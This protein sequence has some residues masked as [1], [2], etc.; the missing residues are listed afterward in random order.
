MCRV[1]IIL[2][3]AKDLLL[4]ENLYGASDANLCVGPRCPCE[5]V[6]ADKGSDLSR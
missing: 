1:V 5:T 3:E 6:N 4:S 2:S